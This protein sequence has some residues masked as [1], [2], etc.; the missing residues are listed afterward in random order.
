MLKLGQVDEVARP[1]GTF[2]D[3]RVTFLGEQGLF[4]FVPAVPEELIPFLKQ[5]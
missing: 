4:V 5:K 3:C 2:N 1:D